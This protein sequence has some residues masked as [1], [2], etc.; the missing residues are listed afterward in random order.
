MPASA[1][2]GAPVP[3]RRVVLL[4]VDGL[5]WRIVR[6]GAAEGW[7]PN[8]K[9]LVAVGAWAEVP[10]REC[11]P[12]LGGWAELDLNSPTLWTTIATGQYYFRH[13]VFDFRNRLESFAQPPLFG[14]RHVRSARIWDVLTRYELSS[15]VVGYYVTH[16]AYPIRGVMVSD[17]FGESAG[18][19]A[20][21]LVRLD[22]F[23]MAAGA[24]SYASLVNQL[25]RLASEGTSTATPEPLAPA[26]RELARRALAEFTAL[27]ADQIAALLDEPSEAERRRLV[28]FY[29]LHPLLRDERMH[30]VARHL[31]GRES[32]HFATAYYR[33]PDYVAHTFWYEDQ[34]APTMWRG[35]EPVL[36]RAYKHFDRQLG[37]IRAAL[38]S[39]SVLIV[40]SDHGFGAGP[41]PGDE[42]NGPWRWSR[43]GKHAEPGVLIVAGGGRTGRVSEPVSL[44][45]LAPSILNHF[46][47]PLAATL[48]GGVV[49]GLLSADA[50]HTAPRLTDY[51]FTP[52]A[53]GDDLAPD[54][55]E[56][57][58]TRLAAL[59]YIE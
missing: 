32:W 31:L 30:A 34:S 42:S 8:L 10:I 39:E 37:E 48:D 19:A 27:S 26:S 1:P 3:N 36:E 51:A 17:L 54:E 52:P 45:D 53:A 56:R 12:G 24:N 59:G 14:S 22:E 44:L 4:A 28:E 13:G 58:E 47:V 21:P 43:M 40:V 9:A 18:G 33:L 2:D 16:P 20:F 7:L 35:F 50:A 38:P 46:G 5:E 15:L 41:G 23:A 57:I 55:R 11:V 6:R 49:P 25:G 29:L